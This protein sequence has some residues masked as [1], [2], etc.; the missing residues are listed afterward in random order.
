MHLRRP[1]VETNEGL[2]DAQGAGTDQ[3][4]CQPVV[5]RGEGEDVL[6][7]GRIYRTLMPVI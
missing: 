1:R 2:A 7:H 3:A 5:E 4:E 6:P